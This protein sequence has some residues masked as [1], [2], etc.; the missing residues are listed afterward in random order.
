MLI[1]FLETIAILYCA[2]SYLSCAYAL[3]HTWSKQE[4]LFKENIPQGTR[5]FAA[6]VFIVFA[7]VVIADVMVERF[8]G[9]R[10]E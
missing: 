5:A 8:L 1:R 6:V 7:P 4:G 2:A 9:P 10:V 3:W